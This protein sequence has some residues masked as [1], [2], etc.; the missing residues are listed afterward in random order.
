[1]NFYL[2]GVYDV[3]KFQIFGMEEFLFRVSIS[4]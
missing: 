4:P 2:R 3:S 1:M